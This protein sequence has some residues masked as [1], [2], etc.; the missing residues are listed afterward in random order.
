MRW[1]ALDPFHTSNN[2]SYGRCFFLFAIL[3]FVV[4]NHIESNIA[5][6]SLS[7]GTSLLLGVLHGIMG[8]G[9]IV[10]LILWIADLYKRWRDTVRTPDSR[11][12]VVFMLILVYSAVLITATAA[13]IVLI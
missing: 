3:S 12:V 2:I 10:A 6:H 13:L 11:A 4:S 9:I 8:I 1:L 5:P 7:V